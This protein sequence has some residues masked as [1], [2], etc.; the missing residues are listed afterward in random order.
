MKHTHARAN[1]FKHQLFEAG[2]KLACQVISKIRLYCT[3][4][5]II[6]T[7]NLSEGM[8]VCVFSSKNLP[9][10]YKKYI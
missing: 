7:A 9:I 5:N 6:L 3:A 2:V 8:F 10:V 1:T 4:T